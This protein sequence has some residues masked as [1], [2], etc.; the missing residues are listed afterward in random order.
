MFRLI[1]MFY[2]F[3]IITIYTL[4]NVLGAGQCYG[5]D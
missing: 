2:I 1:N 4:M 5:K 3:V